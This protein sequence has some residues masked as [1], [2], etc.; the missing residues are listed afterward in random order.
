MLDPSSTFLSPSSSD[1]PSSSSSS[2]SL[3]V[4]TPSPQ[5]PPSA[6]GLPAI[7]KL[8]LT[9]LISIPCSL[10]VLPGRLSILFHLSFVPMTCLEAENVLHHF[11]IPLRK[12]GRYRRDLNVFTYKNPLD[13]RIDSEM[14]GKHFDG[15]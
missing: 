7:S 11:V 8:I 6:I 3:L 4:L 12:V 5:A 9:H 15:T 2:P 10:H 14:W 13:C 1:L